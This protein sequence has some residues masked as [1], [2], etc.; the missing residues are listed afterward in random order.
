MSAMELEG[1]EQQTM[2]YEDHAPAPLLD[3]LELKL[4]SFY[5]AAIAEFVAT[6]LF[7]YIT[8]TTVVENKASKGTCG[9]VGLLGEASAFGGMISVL[10]YCIS[11]ISGGHVNPAVTF[12]LFLARKLSLPRALLYVVAQCLGALCGTALV[13][14][15]QGSFYA[16][17]GGGSNSVSPAYSKG[18]ALLAEII[19]TFVV[20][21][22]VF[23]AADPKRKAR[24]SHI[25]VLAPIPIGLAVFLVHLATIP[26]TGTGIN[27][28]RSF[29]PAVIYGH[30]KSWDDL[31]IFWVGSLI[32][33]A[34]AA[35]Y[36]QYVLRAARFGRKTSGS[37]SGHLT[38]EV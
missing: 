19:G 3:S 20:V 7:L 9:G 18:T 34:V 26:I 17:N 1:G 33:A 8:L 24:H 14:G 32:G 13:R 15:M 25:P 11:A 16:S 35:V 36:N 22:T 21:Y 30:Q 37:L 27:P 5:R 12:A 23:S 2:E 38:T 4:W 29:G 31:W 6:L 10:I 28:A